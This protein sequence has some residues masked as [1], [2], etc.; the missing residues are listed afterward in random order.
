MA[1]I[2]CRSR[3]SP[4][5]LHG[6]PEERIYGKGAS[7]DEDGTWDGESVVCDACYIA[8]GQPSIPVEHPHA[9]GFGA[10]IDQGDPRDA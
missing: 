4:S 2:N 6:K 9:P 1:E 3:R 10:S 7:Q 5:C 8:M